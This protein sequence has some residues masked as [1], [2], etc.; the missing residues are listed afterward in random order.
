MTCKLRLIVIFL[1]F[2][3]ISQSQSTQ[4]G[5]RDQL[6]FNRAETL[7]DIGQYKSAQV[8]FSDLEASSNNP[9]IVS[10]A[11]YYTAVCAIRLNLPMAQNRLESFLDN[12]PTSPR[13]NLIFLEAGDYYFSK[14]KLAYAKKWYQNVEPDNLRA[15]Q[16][17]QFFFRYGYSN[18]RTDNF[19]Q[20]K[21]CFKN[22]EFSDQYGSQARYYL[23][24][25]AYQQDDYDSASALFQDEDVE[26]QFGEEL[27]YFKADL[28]F[29]LGAFQ[30]AID[31]S[32][33]A[34][35]GASSNEVSELNKI[36][37]ESYF[38][39][40][41]YDQ[42][43]PYLKQYNGKNG[44]W[45]HVDFYQ[46]GYAYYKQ[47]LLEEAIGEFNKIIGGDNAL[48]QNAYYHLAECYIK[49]NQKEE[50]LN[51]FKSASELTFNLKIQED[52]WLNYAK[53]SY[54]IGNPYTSVSQVLT[55]FLKQ[56]PK[57]PFVNTIESLLVDSYVSSK[58]YKE[59]L[60]L[61]EGNMRNAL[62]PV[63]QK[64]AFYRALELYGQNELVAAKLLFDKVISSKINPEFSARAYFWKAEIDFNQLN[65]QSALDGYLAFKNTT[66]P[67]SNLLE[68][69]HLE[70]NL[71]YTY[72]KLKQYEKAILAFQ[73]YTLKPNADELL[74]QDAYLRK[75]DAYFVTKNYRKAIEWYNKSVQ[76]KDPFSDYATFQMAICY[77]FLGETSTKISTLKSVLNYKNSKYLDDINFELANTY[78]TLNESK[79]AVEFYDNVIVKFPQS[80]WVSKALLRKGLLLYNQSENSKA[81]AVL[82]QVAEEYPATPEAYQAISSVRSLYIDSG[83]VNDYA[84]WV[85]TLPYVSK[86]DIKLETA[87]YEAAEKQ[88]LENNIDRAIILFN[89]YL[90]NYTQGSRQIQAHFYLA[91]LYY[92]QNLKT[93][94][95]P[96]YEY[97]IYQPNNEFSEPA[98]QKV[99]VI[100]LEQ[101]MEATSLLERLEKESK[102]PQHIRFAQSNLMKLFFKEESYNMAIQ[103]S[104]IV[105]NDSR[106][107][108]LIKNDALAIK[109]RSALAQR[110]D[111]LA[112][113][114]FENILQSSSSNYGAEATYHLAY[115]KYKDSDYENSNL[116]IQDLI[117]TYPNNKLFAARGLVLMA[118]NF[119]ALEDTFQ[120][121]YILESVI[122]NFESFAD[123][124]EEAKVL[125][126]QYKVTIRQTNASLESTSNTPNNLKE[127]QL[128]D[129]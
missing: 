93:N 28:K 54:D 65:F 23:G 66:N 59:A 124:T 81:L 36:I 113:I 86:T 24:F 119:Y 46:L 58:N 95:L 42:A 79:S 41:N 47:N 37:G 129:K 123:I 82:K 61:L 80:K 126:N 56:Y 7:F 117:K 77:G 45:T 30:E 68:N 2:N 99:C 10:N 75:A 85:G 100:A 108:R 91:D 48:A 73:N 103:Y 128:D 111:S 12:Y 4:S 6:N 88:Y 21:I 120:A 31:A 125:L 53:L 55:D 1:C 98:L 102:N 105:I 52:A 87:A 97:V 76:S 62:K 83:T 14:T 60:I 116:L 29:K 118:Q 96:H 34:L 25:M 40:E 15:H 50:A 63:Y 9:Q 51:A 39:L 71:G 107:N 78:N 74:L 11:A 90:E 127:Q 89:S 112:K 121:T 92:S 38:N 5:S 70:Y 18:F 114:S 67:N 109:A 20:A 104:D 49:N 16:K 32:L 27:A 33:D 8:L 17:E 44:K 84:K 3:W 101:D 64:V 57:S 94:A 69:S 19:K 22:V 72:F 26:Q 122:D 43:I 13:R 35:D 115:F 110:N 106:T